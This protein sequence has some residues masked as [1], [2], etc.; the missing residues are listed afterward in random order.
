MKRAPDAHTHIFGPSQYYIPFALEL[1]WKYGKWN[2]VRIK[3]G[4]IGGLV[5]NMLK[6]EVGFSCTM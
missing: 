1:R 5:L 4:G 6:I 3:W 2:D